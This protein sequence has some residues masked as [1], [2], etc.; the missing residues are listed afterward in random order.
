MLR[1]VFLLFLISFSG[2]VPAQVIQSP[3]DT[4]S[5]ET[6]I[7]P[8]QLK[9]LLISDPE[10][11]KAA[12]SMDVAVGSGANPVEI[13]GLAHFLE[14]MLF[15]GSEK[16][17]E[18]DSYQS[19]ISA[20]GGSHNAFTAYENTNYFFDVRP[21]A[22]A[23]ALDRFSR[24]LSTRYLLQTMCNVSVTQLTLNFRPSAGTIAVAYMKSP[25]RS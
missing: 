25:N 8:N 17:P 9:V 16:Y 13:P 11:E 20:N 3:Y 6:F 2:F 22:F 10:A 24:F 12:A 4:R 7:L 23:G 5:L 14:H 1:V 21:E 18:A 19:Y 15:L